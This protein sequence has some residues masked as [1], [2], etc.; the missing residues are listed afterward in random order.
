MR[1]ATLRL[2][3][4]WLWAVW[5]SGYSK[6][7]ELISTVTYERWQSWQHNQDR[8]WAVSWSIVILWGDDSLKHLGLIG[9]QHVFQCSLHSCP[10]RPSS[11]ACQFQTIRQMT[12]NNLDGRRS[13]MSMQWSLCKVQ[14]PTRVSFSG[15]QTKFLWKLAKTKFIQHS[16]ERERETERERGREREGGGEGGGGGL[17]FL[18]KTKS[19]SHSS[20]RE[21]RVAPITLC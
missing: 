16:H 5:I 21:M 3:S 14:Y 13:H 2:A 19:W 1:T 4:S 20:S 18:K 17:K 12:T 6:Q 9:A 10:G 7:Q 11:N 8:H 15:Y